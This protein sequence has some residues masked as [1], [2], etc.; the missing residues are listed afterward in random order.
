MQQATNANRACTDKIPQNV[1]NTCTA[2]GAR[3]VYKKAV[4]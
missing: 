2:Q 4:S 1:D 3:R